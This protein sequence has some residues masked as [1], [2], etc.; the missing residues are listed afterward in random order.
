MINSPCKI[1]N[2]EQLVNSNF[3]I[4]SAHIAALRNIT[5][6]AEWGRTLHVFSAFPD[7]TGSATD[8]M[9]LLN[10]YHIRKMEPGDEK[11]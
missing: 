6:G 9:V 8:F 2:S 10:P 4:A 5:H 11:K 3:E 1:S 7:Y